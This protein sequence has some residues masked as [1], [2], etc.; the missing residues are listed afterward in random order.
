MPKREPAITCCKVCTLDNTTLPYI[1]RIANI[2]KTDDNTILVNVLNAP[3]NILFVIK[4]VTKMVTPCACPDGIPYDVAGL[5][6]SNNPASVAPSGRI[7][8][9]IKGYVSLPIIGLKTLCF[10]K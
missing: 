10:K 8:R 5:L 9:P 6:Y 4:Y 1:T 2:I 3:F 7:P